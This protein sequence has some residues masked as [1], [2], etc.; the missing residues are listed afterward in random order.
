[1]VAST[2]CAGVVVGRGCLGRPWLFGQLVAAFTASEA[3]AEPD[4]RAVATVMR[5]HAEL[6][7]ELYGEVKGVRDFRKHHA[8]YTKGFRI[9][10]ETRRALG[11][12]D[13]LTDVDAL[14][15]TMDLDQGYP[16]GAA[17][18]PRGRTSAARRVALP[19]RWLDDRDGLDGFLAELVD[20]ELSVSGG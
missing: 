7:V 4:L 11:L 17:E 8:W 15:A 6:L 18:N 16:S 19:E 10:S 13:T 20:A 12:V 9:G 5:R 2:G 3:P 14:V 1:M